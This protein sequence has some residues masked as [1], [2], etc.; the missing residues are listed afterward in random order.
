VNTFAEQSANNSFELFDRSLETSG[1]VLPV[2]HDQQT[3]RIS[4]GAHALAWVINYWQ[5][6]GAASGDRIFAESPPSNGRGY[7]MAELSRLVQQRGLLASAVRLDRPGLV[8]ELERGR[9][10]LVPVEVP[11]IY[12]E[13]RAL[14]GA[15][16]PVVGLAQGVFAQRAGAIS[17]WTGLGM[18][19][20]YVVVVGYDDDRIVVVEPVMGYRTISYARLAR[21][22]EPFGNAALV[23]SANTPAR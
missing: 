2:V 9:P 18:V 20:H 1:L 22:R 11:A 4:C 12:V 6:A 23:I 19:D 10:V 16:R 13:G 5:G 17:E 7:S 8:R 14:P 15:N 21:Y 3:S